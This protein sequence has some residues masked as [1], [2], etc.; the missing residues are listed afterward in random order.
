[1][2]HLYYDSD[3]S[4]ATL[5]VQLHKMQRA[6]NCMARCAHPNTS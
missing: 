3:M 1:M 5:S 4:L 2:Y 6:T